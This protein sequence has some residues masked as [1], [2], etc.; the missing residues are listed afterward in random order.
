MA[1]VRSGAAPPA[2]VEWEGR[3]YRVD[4]SAAEFRRLQR[5]RRRQGGATIDAALTTRPPASRDSKAG[6][7]EKNGVERPLTEALVSIAYAAH[8]GD[9]DGQALSGGNVAL[10]HDLGLAPMANNVRTPGAWRLP[11]EEFGKNGWKIVGSL[12]GLET[13]L[14]RLALRRLD[15]SEMPS[16]P[17]LSSNE[18][19]T[20]ALTAALINPR[21]LSDT[22]RD[23]I[24]ASIARGR[25]RAGA[26]RADRAELDRLAR[27]AGLSEWRREALGWQL[28]EDRERAIA[29]FSLLEL[30]WLGAPRPSAVAAL[31]AWGAAM[32]PLT[33]CLCVEMPRPRPW[34]EMTGRPATGQLATRGVDVALHVAE[35][36]AALR[37]PAALAAGVIAYA[38]LDA[39]ERAQPAYFDDWPAFARTI[40]ALPRERM[41]DYIAALAAN[42][43]LMPDVVRDA[44]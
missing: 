30:F 12:L 6:G 25:A 19:Q 7:A 1:G 44:Q 23:E 41:V 42:G 20:L 18:R 16:A 3:R 24:A 37:L 11:R 22:A 15:A 43:P 4:P 29:Q 35:T 40:L 32:L 8:L 10:R 14:G 27:D 2:V 33:G 17:R 36:L 21:A 26:L 34:E 5:M 13:A 9:P 28:T 38:S 31:D 39:V